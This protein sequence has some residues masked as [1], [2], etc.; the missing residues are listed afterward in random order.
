[1][2]TFSS[3]KATEMSDI[4]RKGIGGEGGVG[5]WAVVLKTKHTLNVVRSNCDY[6]VALVLPCTSRCLGA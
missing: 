4:K 6:S 2:S 1:M 5:E 3:F